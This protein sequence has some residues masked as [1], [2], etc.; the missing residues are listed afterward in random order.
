MVG[1]EA[2]GGGVLAR[3]TRVTVFTDQLIGQ[4]T[5]AEHFQQNFDGGA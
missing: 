3:G 4:E 5:R 2:F 1:E